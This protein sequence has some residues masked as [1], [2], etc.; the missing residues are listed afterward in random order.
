MDDEESGY[1]LPAAYLMH[2]SSLL[3]TIEN[4]GEELD[5]RHM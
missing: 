3:C 4:N 1:V 2:A 5:D